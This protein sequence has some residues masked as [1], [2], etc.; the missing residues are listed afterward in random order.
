MRHG[1]SHGLRQGL[2]F[3]RDHAAY[4]KA[5]DSANGTCQHNQS[6]DGNYYFLLHIFLRTAN[7]LW[8][9]AL[10]A[11]P[12]RHTEADM[13]VVKRFK[14]ESTPNEMMVLLHH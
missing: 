14:T 2:F 5:F 11:T 7:T 4:L 13:Y 10:P 1:G 8:Q 9:H 6:N 3:L 12:L